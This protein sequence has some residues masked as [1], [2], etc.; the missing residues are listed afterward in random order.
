MEKYTILI[1]L[2]VEIPTDIRSDLEHNTGKMMDELLS[3]DTE[4]SVNNPVLCKYVSNVTT[5]IPSSY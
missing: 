3:L 1:Q 5:F 4:V 2:E